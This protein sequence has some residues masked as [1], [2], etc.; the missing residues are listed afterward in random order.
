MQ[1]TDVK[2][3]VWA[4]PEETYFNCMVDF[5]TLGW[6]PFTCSQSDPTPYAQSIWAETM[7]GDYGP[8]GPY[9][10]PPPP[11]EPPVDPAA[12]PS[13]SGAQTL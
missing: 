13:V 7:N 10:P 5:V 11:P 8:I 2:D 3:P 9:V 6:V 12:Q 1:Y 4:D